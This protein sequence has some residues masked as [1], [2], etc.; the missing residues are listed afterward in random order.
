MSSF[1]ATESIRFQ[2]DRQ[3][4]L[5]LRALVVRAHVFET[6]LPYLVRAITW[7]QVDR[8]L[9]FALGAFAVFAHLAKQN[10]VVV[11]RLRLAMIR[12]SR[13]LVL[14]LSTPL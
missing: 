10:A 7:D 14:A 12:L 1:L 4:L 11:L 5:N 8:Q 2:F 6:T 3:L 9:V 13:Q